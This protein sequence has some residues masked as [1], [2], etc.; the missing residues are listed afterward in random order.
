M[1]DRK[2]DEMREWLGMT[3]DELVSLAD[4]LVLRI[5]SSDPIDKWVELVRLVSP[6]KWKELTGEARVA[7]DHRIAAEML[8]RLRDDL[9]TE[10]L[11]PALEVP[12]AIAWTPQHDRLN[13]RM[14]DLDRILT[15][16]GI[17]PHPSLV[18]PLEGATEM[19]LVGRSMEHLYVPRRRDYIELFDIGG[20][21][22]D[23]GLLARYVAV[24]E[25]GREVRSDLVMLNR[26]VTRIMVVTDPE[27]N[28]RTQ[29]QRDTKRRQILGSIYA[30]LPQ[31]FRTERARSQLDSVVTI[32]TWTDNESF[33]FA[34]FTNDE[35]AAAIRRV[36]EEG[37][38]PEPA[39][40]AA[41]IDAIRQ[42]RGNL[43]SLL[44]KYP[45]LKRRKDRLADTLWPTLRDRLDQHVKDATIETIPV[46]RVLKRA[47]DLATMSF[48]RSVALEL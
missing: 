21:T 7:I 46:G 29:D 37:G 22:N 6:D 2:A 43:K 23:Y 1:R 13:R 12:P 9:T 41:E 42:R 25:L 18:L 40:N 19:I 17:S 14:D 38:L 47:V 32:D 4:G 16:Y 26:P 33:E 5:K 48:R 34:H 20:N 36:H 8:M 28:L 44:R 39:V 35:I 10:G 27:N 11:A 45:A 24:P 31:R 30:S 15:D 3:P